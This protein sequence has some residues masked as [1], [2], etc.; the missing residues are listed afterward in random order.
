MA[1][2]Y[3]NVISVFSNAEVIAT[4]IV[5]TQYIVASLSLSVVSQ[6]QI[7]LSLPIYQNS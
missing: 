3:F 6:R 4:Q 5:T 7:Y 1:L 2:E